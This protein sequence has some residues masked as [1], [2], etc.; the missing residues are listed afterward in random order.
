M[1]ETADYHGSARD[2]PEAAKAAF[3]SFAETIDRRSQIVW[4]EHCTECAYPD[5]YTTCAF[6]KPRLDGNCRR[7]IDGVVPGRAGDTRTAYVRFDR[8]AK[9]EG[10][11]PARLKALAEVERRERNDR[12]ASQALGAFSASRS[13]YANG[14]RLWNRAK[15]S[16]SA[17]LS[18]DAHA[19]AVE[20]WCETEPKIHFMLSIMPTAC[21]EIGFQMRFELAQGYNR[22]IAPIEDIRALVDLEAEHLIQITPSGDNSPFAC[23]FG[24]I[25]FVRF[26]TSSSLSAPKPLESAQPIKCIVWD[27]DNTLWRGTLVEDGEEALELDPAMR[28]LVREFDQ[29]GVLQSIASKNE[30]AAALSALERFGLREFFLFPEIGWGPKSQSLKRIAENLDIGL[31]TF[32]FVDDQ[33]FERAEVGEALGQVTVVAHTE[34][35]KLAD[36]PRLALPKTLESAKRRLMYRAEESRRAT[37]RQSGADYVSFLRSSDISLRISP[38]VEADADRAYELGQR[39][40][41]LNVSARRYSRAEIHAMLAPD[42]AERAFTFR[43]EDRFGDYGLVGLCVVEHDSGVIQSFMMSCRVQRRHVE[44]AFFA[45]LSGR[46]N[47]NG[48]GSRLTARFKTSARNSPALRMLAELGFTPEAPGATEGLMTRATDA[49]FANSDIVRVE[50]S[51]AARREAAL[52]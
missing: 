48:L 21:G 45:W 41:Q 30:E 6:Y 37:F 24:L 46:L 23:T 2:L 36:H 19:F 32:V 50:E 27:L 13:L 5:C 18:H 1:F 34:V 43:V 52:V 44:N 40:N 33:P 47:E 12:L 22:L 35:G 11:G 39:T 14:A 10:V 31:D 8:W 9:I 20:V 15:R 38:L 51:S 28:D 7:F 3:R 29:R 49:P 25:D 4:G 42:S 17:G 16:A 26:N